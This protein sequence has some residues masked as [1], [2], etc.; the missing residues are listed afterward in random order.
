[1]QSV[2]KA[3]E[4]SQ[5]RWLFY[6]TSVCTEN[7]KYLDVNAAL[8]YKPDPSVL[9]LVASTKSIQIKAC[10]RSQTWLSE[11]KSLKIKD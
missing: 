7:I 4:G 6:N 3:L 1:M 9:A 2:V 5:T 10:R 8:M 11:G